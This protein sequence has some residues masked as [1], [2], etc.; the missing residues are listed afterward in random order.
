MLV[1]VYFNIL[2]NMVNNPRVFLAFIN[3]RMT[4]ISRKPQE[5]VKS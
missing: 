3:T 2:L 5:E 4:P 1:T